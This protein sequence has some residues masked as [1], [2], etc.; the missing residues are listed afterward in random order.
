MRGACQDLTVKYGHFVALDHINLNI[1]EGQSAIVLGE[2]GA[3]KSTL[4]RTLAGWIRP[5]NGRVAI[6]D[7]YLAQQERQVRAWV[8]LVPDTPQFYSDLTV[9]EH[10]E[11]VAQANHIRHWQDEATSLLTR[12]GIHRNLR[13]FPSRFSR[14]MQYKL[15]LVMS[16]ITKPE[17]LLLDEPYGPL[18]PDSQIFLAKYL[19]ELVA[20]GVSVLLSTHVLPDE[21][22]PHRI[23]VLEQGRLVL[24]S[25]VADV[26]AAGNITLA[27]LPHNVLTRVLAKVRASDA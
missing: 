14:G 16:L 20:S 3:G 23:L 8:K 17:L 4:L 24:D 9:W 11:I 7:Q 18:D 2:N 19:A 10:L 1:P 12:F 15:A 6:N 27:S 5:T 21:G 13:S 22:A 26:M 25:F